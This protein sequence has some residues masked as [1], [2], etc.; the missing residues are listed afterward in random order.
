MKKVTKYLNKLVHVVNIFKKKIKYITNPCVRI[1]ASITH[2]SACIPLLCYQSLA[3]TNLTKAKR[4]LYIKMNK[5][6][7]RKLQIMTKNIFEY[8]KK[9]SRT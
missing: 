1:T 8:M 7:W 9:L 2:E 3:N 5:T 4:T 6:G